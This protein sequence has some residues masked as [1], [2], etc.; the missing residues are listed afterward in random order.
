LW[1]CLQPIFLLSYT[2]TLRKSGDHTASVFE[3]A[4]RCEV[5]TAVVVESSIP[6]DRTLYEYVFRLGQEVKF[7]RPSETR[8]EMQL[9]SILSFIFLNRAQGKM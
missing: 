1:N 5:I 2:Q 9:S 4:A 3:R 7:F 6:D 8:R